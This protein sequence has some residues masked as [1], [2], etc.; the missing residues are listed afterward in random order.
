LKD[1]Y[2]IIKHS[3]AIKFVQRNRSKK[4]QGPKSE[5]TSP[6]KMAHNEKEVQALTLN[7]VHK[8]RMG[9]EQNSNTLLKNYKKK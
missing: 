4:S 5:Q 2:G 6:I 8:V 9:F 7:S 3:P 1:D